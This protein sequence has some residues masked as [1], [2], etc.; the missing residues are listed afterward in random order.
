MLGMTFNVHVLMDEDIDESHGDL[1]EAVAEA[2]EPYATRLDWWTLGGTTK[3]F[4]GRSDVTRVCEVDFI[5]A[6]V[7]AACAAADE[8]SALSKLALR[9]DNP[10]S[11]YETQ[12]IKRRIDGIGVPYALIDLEGKW[13]ERAQK[14]QDT[15]CQDYGIYLNTVPD[16]S[17]VANV[18][19]GI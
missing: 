3:P 9:G 11:S 16:F 12:Y 1:T 17:W 8:I 15:W 7:F 5:M 13:H 4:F 14:P 2:M 18:Q 10:L 6:K 19:C